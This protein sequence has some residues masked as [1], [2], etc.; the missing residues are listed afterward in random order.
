MSEGLAHPCKRDGEAGVNLFWGTVLSMSLA[1]CAAASGKLHSQQPLC[2][3]MG[4]R[5]A[6]REISDLTN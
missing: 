6:D 2:G 4:Q 1:L 3:A 5:P